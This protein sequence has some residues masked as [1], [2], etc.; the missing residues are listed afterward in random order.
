MYY[1]VKPAVGVRMFFWISPFPLPH[2]HPPLHR[3][4]PLTTMGRIFI[5]SNA[6]IRLVH[7]M[8]F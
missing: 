5:A 8:Y 1:Y 6:R 2:A 4:V 7:S 3:N